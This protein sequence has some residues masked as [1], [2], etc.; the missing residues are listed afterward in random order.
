MFVEGFVGLSRNRLNK[1]SMSQKQDKTFLVKKIMWS[2]NRAKNDACT[3]G[4]DRTPDLL[5][6]ALYQCKA[7]IITTR[8][9]SLLDELWQLIKL[10]EIIRLVV[11]IIAYR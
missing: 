7:D 4:E 11:Q 1:F 10:N 9:R 2:L 5:R 3:S 6:F 8:L